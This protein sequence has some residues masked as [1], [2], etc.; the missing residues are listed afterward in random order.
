MGPAPTPVGP[1][2]QP[3]NHAPAFEWVNPHL[4]DHEFLPDAQQEES[5]PADEIVFPPPRPYKGLGYAQKVSKSIAQWA[6]LEHQV[7]AA[8]LHCQYLTKNWTTQDCYLGSKT[9]GCTCTSDAIPQHKMDLI[10]LI[11]YHPEYPVNLCGC[12]PE[13]IQ[14]IYQGYLPSSPQK[15]RTAF[16][17]R[18]MQHHESMWHTNVVSKTGYIGGHVRF[19]QNQHHDPMLARSE[20]SQHQQHNRDLSVPFSNTIDLF[21]SILDLHKSTLNEGMQRTKMDL[22]ADKCSRCFGPAES[23]R[24]VSEKEPH[25]IFCMDGNF[26]QRHNTLA[27]ND[28]PTDSQYPPIFIPPSEILDSKGELQ[29][30]DHINPCSD[31]HR[32]A[33][34]TRNSST[35]DRCDDTGLFAA[36]CRHDIPLRVANIFKTGEKQ[37]YPISLI[38]SIVSDFPNKQFGILYD[39]GCQLE[40]HMKCRDLLP[41]DRGRLSFATSVFHAYVHNWTCQLQYNPRYN[42]LW[43]LSDGEGLERLWSFLSPLVPPLRTSTRWHRLLAIARRINY[44]SRGIQDGSAAWLLKRLMVA[45]A[46][47]TE[48]KQTVNDICQKKRPPGDQLYTVEFLAQQWQAQKLALLHPDETKR[49]QQLELGKLLCLEDQYNDLWNSVEIS[50]QQSITRLKLTADLSKQISDQKKKIGSASIISD[51]SEPHHHLLLKVWHTKAEFRQLYLMLKEEKRP[52]EEV[53]QPGSASKLGHRGEQKVMASLTK[54][55]GKL[56]P[57]IETYNKYV[58]EFNAA[59]TGRLPL[60][61]ITYKELMEAQPDDHFWNDGLFTYGDQPWATDH[62]T[63]V[64]MRALARQTRAEEEIRRLGWEVRRS[65]RWAVARVSQLIS[66]L[67]VFTA[68]AP[69]N[70]PP[71]FMS[72]VNHPDFDSLELSNRLIVAKVLLHTEFVQM[73]RLQLSWNWKLMEAFDLTVAQDGD[74]KLQREWNKQMNLHFYLIHNRLRSNILGDCDMMIKGIAHFGLLSDELWVPSG[75]NATVEEEEEPEAVKTGGEDEEQC[76]QEGIRMDSLYLA[77]SLLE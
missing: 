35:W 60:R 59:N 20:Q 22:W 19:L 45:M 13:A 56:R 52:L 70:F 77:L 16:S 31:S 54:K 15:P 11:T 6:A 65:M 3:P 14:L 55:A 34:D 24:Q 40:K 39:I 33:N 37:Y 8:Y 71:T 64:G 5:N 75:L 9:P 76:L 72:L 32:A 58:K 49:S 53:R 2:E 67:L 26:Q 47:D 21:A 61:T 69:P 36:A 63:Q 23:E 62:Y 29:S 41:G 18:L 42:E 38:K 7:F 74:G 48:C 50:P 28:T 12:K 57:M 46:T 51:L 25:V 4:D 17:I 1:P 68:G 73:S 43:G 66:H 44:Y 27:S 30:T 10:D